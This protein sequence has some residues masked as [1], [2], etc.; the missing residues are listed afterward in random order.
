[1]IPAIADRV[2]S[3]FLLIERIKSFGFQFPPAGLPS[4]A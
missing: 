3:D 1:M 4:L 2:R